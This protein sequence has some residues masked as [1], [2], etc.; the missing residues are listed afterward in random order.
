MVIIAAHI[1]GYVVPPPPRY[2]DIHV[3]INVLISFLGFMWLYVLLTVR[4]VRAASAAPKKPVSSSSPATKKDDDVKDVKKEESNAKA[5]RKD[6]VKPKN[7][8]S[9][10]VKTN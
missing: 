9:K 3:V 10:K 8:Q 1:A 4:L 2:P 7:K 5:I 6:N